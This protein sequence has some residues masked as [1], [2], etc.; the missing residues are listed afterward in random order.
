MLAVTPVNNQ[1]SS[2]NFKS[3]LKSTKYLKDALKG[4]IDENIARQF[5]HDNLNKLANDGLNRV[6][7][8]DYAKGKFR[9]WLQPGAFQ[10]TVDGVKRPWNYHFGGG[11]VVVQCARAIESITEGVRYKDT[12]SKLA[13]IKKKM[14][15]A[16]ETYFLYDGKGISPEKTE[17]HFR[18]KYEFFNKLYHKTLKEDLVS[19]KNTLSAKGIWGK[20]N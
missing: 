4:S 5:L 14:R 15:D 12:G 20:G 9:Q 10:V 2:V 6:V 13:K 3:Y 8:I 7:E 16:R 18:K 1:N 11:G 19:I 17:K